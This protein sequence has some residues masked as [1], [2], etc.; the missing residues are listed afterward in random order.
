MMGKADELILIAGEDGESFGNRLNQVI[1]E[2]YFLLDETEPETAS[3]DFCPFCHGRNGQCQIS[4]P[5][6]EME[7][8]MAEDEKVYTAEPIFD[9]V[10]EVELRKMLDDNKIMVEVNGKEYPFPLGDMKLTT[11]YI[12]LYDCF[13]EL[14]SIENL[15]HFL[16][17]NNKENRQGLCYRIA[18][19]TITLYSF[20]LDLTKLDGWSKIM[21]LEGYIDVIEA[22][23]QQQGREYEYGWDLIPITPKD[24]KNSFF[25]GENTPPFALELVDVTRVLETETRIYRE[26]SAV[27]EG[28]FSRESIRFFKPVQYE[29]SDRKKM[30][31]TF[32]AWLVALMKLG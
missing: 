30:K 7:P 14:P 17:F 6:D 18:V 31:E 15:A 28:L 16:G 11:R 29:C 26:I 32:H 3:N 1:L 8:E 21:L 25:I 13:A 2:R 19:P 12:H 23:C 4:A 27:E 24:L 10:F 20:D 22:L 5:E 9:T